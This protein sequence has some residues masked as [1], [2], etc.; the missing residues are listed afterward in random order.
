MPLD[1]RIEMFF[2]L[3]SSGRLGDRRPGLR[4]AQS[5]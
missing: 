5:C 3:P 1:R 2:P 4:Q